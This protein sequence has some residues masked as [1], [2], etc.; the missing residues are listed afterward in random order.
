MCGGKADLLDL[1]RLLD[2]KIDCAYGKMASR[3][4]PPR[5][6][7]ALLLA[8]PPAPQQDT[9]VCFKRSHSGEGPCEGVR[10][11]EGVDRWSRTRLLT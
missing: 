6:P 5:P 11:R 3:P 10:G 9:Q 7:R 8:V 4:P 1:G 2:Y